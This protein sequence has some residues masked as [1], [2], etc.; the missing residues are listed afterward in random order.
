[1]KQPSAIIFDLDGTLIDS[2]YSII[3]C[4]ERVQDKLNIS[5]VR[6]ISEDLIGAP[7]KEIIPAIYGSISENVLQ[8]FIKLFSEEYDRVGYRWGRPYPGVFEL[9]D[10]LSLNSLSLSIVTNKRITPTRLILNYFG[11]EK[12]FE[13]VTGID[14][15]KPAF[16]N[17]YL[18]LNHHIAELGRSPDDCMYIGDRLDDFRAASGNRI[19]CVLVGW[20]YGSADAICAEGINSVDSLADLQYLLL[21]RK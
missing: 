4:L 2:R 6:Q 9:L 1:M 20:G 8:N 21:D 10:S 15:A 7:L 19:D 17:K 13:S 3:T 5:P 18:A 11:M 16:V 14:S 12:Y